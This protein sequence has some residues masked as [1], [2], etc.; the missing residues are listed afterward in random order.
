MYT[1]RSRIPVEEYL[2]LRRRSFFIG[3]L[4]RMMQTRDKEYLVHLVFKPFTGELFGEKNT[5]PQ[6]TT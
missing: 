6:V 1:I 2:D 3:L 4:I 5:H